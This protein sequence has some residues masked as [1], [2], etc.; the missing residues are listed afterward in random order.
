[1]GSIFEVR[2]VTSSRAAIWAV[3]MMFTKV[4]VLYKFLKMEFLVFTLSFP[5]VTQRH[6]WSKNL[7]VKTYSAS[8]TR[9]E[10]DLL[11]RMWLS[12][13]PETLLLITLL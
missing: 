10:R 8:N 3:L 12:L 13:L 2:P 4:L 5:K 11:T 7:L 6:L 9:N 1:M